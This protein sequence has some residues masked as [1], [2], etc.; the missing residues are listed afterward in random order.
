MSATQV[1]SGVNANGEV[2]GVV[3]GT[4]VATTSG[5]AIDFTGIPSG[6]KKITVNFIGVSTTGASDIIVQLG[7]SA[8]VQSTGY[9]GS[10]VDSTQGNGVTFTAGFITNNLQAA[11]DLAHGT[12]VI[13]LENTDSFTWAE[14]SSISDSVIGNVSS[15]AGSKS[16]SAELT[17]VRI[18]T[19]GGSDT[20]DAGALNISYEG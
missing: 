5:T 17:Q 13:N 4:A 2:L 8:G 3:L 14:L 11:G 19:T 6:T 9:V 16:L 12:M 7:D 20:F 10:N 1:T 18:T 15:G